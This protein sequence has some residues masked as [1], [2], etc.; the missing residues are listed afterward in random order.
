MNEQQARTAEPG[1]ETD[2][3]VAEWMGDATEMRCPDDYRGRMAAKAP[4]KYSTSAEHAMSALKAL[5]ETMPG[6]YLEPMRID[7]WHVAIPPMGN[8]SWDAVLAPT[9]EL[10]IAR[11]VLVLKARGVTREGLS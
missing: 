4:R 9:P 11:A 3:A 1:P 10:A 5:A 7:Q 8:V 6:F 2:R